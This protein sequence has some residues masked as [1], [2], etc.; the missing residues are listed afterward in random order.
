M[1][2][3]SHGMR[4]SASVSMLD[5]FLQK[6]TVPVSRLQLVG[7]AMLLIA[8]KFEETYYLPP[9]ELA[10]LSDGDFSRKLLV[11]MERIVL[12]VLEWQ[13]CIPTTLTF[14]RRW[15]KLANLDARQHAL[16][17][18]IAEISLADYHVAMHRPSLQAASSVYLTRRMDQQQPFWPCE[19][20]IHTGYSE[21]A[22]L[23]CTRSMNRALKAA[24]AASTDECSAVVLKYKAAFLHR[25]STIPTID[26]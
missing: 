6:R 24:H 25:V 12:H 5:R 9:K 16:A 20:E 7:A 2:L 8:S 14:L 26:I 22:L 21:E 4:S 17:R 18:Y 1:M 15:S 11:G 23:R 13:L 10:G 3:L 19:L